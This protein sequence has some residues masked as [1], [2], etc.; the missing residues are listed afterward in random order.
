MVIQLGGGNKAGLS[1]A[2][3]EAGPPV[4]LNTVT[5][6]TTGM[7]KMEEVRQGRFPSPVNSLAYCLVR[8][9]CISLLVAVSGK[10]KAVD[11]AI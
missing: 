6:H 2:K 11:I 4:R 10:G 5:P 9:A 1:R 7:K 8:V 3:S